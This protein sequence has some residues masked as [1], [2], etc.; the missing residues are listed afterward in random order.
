MRGKKLDSPAM[1]RSHKGVKRVQSFMLE[2]EEKDISFY[3]V[4]DYSYRHR[5]RDIEAFRS[6][7]QEAFPDMKIDIYDAVDM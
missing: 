2:K 5:N 3:V 7:V 4:P 6:E 1:A